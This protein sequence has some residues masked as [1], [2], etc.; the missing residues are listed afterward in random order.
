MPHDLRHIFEHVPS[1]TKYKCRVEYDATNIDID[2]IPYINPRV[3]SLQVIVDDEI[4]YDFKSADRSGL[5]DLFNRRKEA[6]DIMIIKNGRITD[7]YFAN[8]AFY[9]GIDW[10]T[11][12]FPLL[13][14]VKRQNLLDTGSIKEKDVFV[15][16]LGDFQTISLINAMND[17]GDLT[18]STS[19][20]MV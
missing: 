7:S 8:L 18:V 19:D 9:D 3:N 12:K 15:D 13:N 4:N 16:E 11:P 5:T 10:W 6:D 17:L 1:D 14:G 20:V 2:F